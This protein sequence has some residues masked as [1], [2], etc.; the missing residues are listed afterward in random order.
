MLKTKITKHFSVLVTLL[1]LVIALEIGFISTL[2]INWVQIEAGFQNIKL[3]K[4]SVPK[5]FIVQSGSME[6]SIKTGSLVFSIPQKNYR[7][8]EVVTF[9]PGGSMQALSPTGSKKNLVTHRIVEVSEEGEYVTK[10][11]ANEEADTQTISAS[12][13][14]GRTM[15][16]VPY[17]GFLAN[18]AKDPKGFILLVI[19]P[20]TIVIYEEL[21]NL[22]KEIAKIFSKLLAKLPRAKRE[23]G[24]GEGHYDYIF[25]SPLPK[26]KNVPIYAVAVPV[27][28][29]LL[30]LVA[31]SASYFSDHEKSSSN[32]LGAAESFGNPTPTGSST[33]TPTPT[34]GQTPTVGGIVINEVYYDPD[35]AHMQP[36][37]A[38]ENNFEWVEIYNSSSVTVNLKDWKITDATG[39]ERTIST[40]NRDLG[41]GE[42]AVLAKAANAF[43][44]WGI[45]SS[46]QIPLGEIIGSGLNNT[47]DAVI[48]KDSLGTVVDQMSYGTNISVFNPSATDVAEGH[49]LEREPDGTDTN[50][51]ADFVNRTIPSPGS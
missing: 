30:V 5:A 7:V 10:G 35:T 50:T 1:S 15:L 25:P 22:K 24:S 46:Q 44:L 6:P 33:L 4:G 8:G 51:A 49:S 27:L 41:P 45:P 17:L 29:V 39:T 12:Q 42:F 13:I 20:A 32:I 38:D 26:N 14:V 31:F 28:G 36:P 40:S 23:V 18:F 34:Q 43:V 47:G 19:V 3:G 9:H 2:F 16:P 11:D 37:T 48:L 21:K